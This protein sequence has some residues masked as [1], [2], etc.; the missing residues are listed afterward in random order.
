[1]ADAEVK[2]E[3]T[4]GP[5]RSRGCSQGNATVNTLTLIVLAI[6]MVGVF[7][8]AYEAAN[9]NKLTR[10][11]IDV[12]SRPYLQILVNRGDIQKATRPEMGPDAPTVITLGFVVA[13]TGR[14]PAQ[15]M[16]QSL[17]KYSA[18]KLSVAPTLDGVKPEYH[19]IWPPGAY[20]PFFALGNENISPGQFN[21]IRSGLG[22][23]Y[24]VAKVAY[25]DYATG[26]CWQL[27]IEA[28]ADLKTNPSGTNLGSI[29]KFEN[30]P[31]DPKTH[32][33]AD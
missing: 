28:V 26:V 24:F 5:D 2:K 10:Q 33:Y 14:L 20:E 31:G 6:T 8:Y 30:C 15:A 9:A 27:P 18:E 12:Q 4:K 16:V 32:N 25:G 23:V 22:Y 21:D 29:N 7:W 17:A 19:F 1:M 13:N 3:N 11:A